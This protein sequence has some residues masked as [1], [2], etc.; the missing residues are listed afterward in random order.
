MD[1][2]EGDLTDKAET[3]SKIFENPGYFRKPT[4]YLTYVLI[5]F[6]TKVSTTSEIRPEVSPISASESDLEE[7]EQSLPFFDKSYGW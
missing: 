4:I 5:S 6:L 3:L 1:C 2:E 7:K